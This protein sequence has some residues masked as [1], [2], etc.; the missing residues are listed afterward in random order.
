MD[1]P[2]GA[3]KV[4]EFRAGVGE[5]YDRGWRRIAAP[6]TWWDG[7][8]RVKIAGE[9][10]RAETCNL[11]QQRRDAVSWGA[12]EG[13]HDSSGELPEHLVEII[14]RVRSD[15]SRINESWVHGLSAQGVSEEQY[16]ELIGVVATTIA[17]DT[18]K[19]AALQ[20]LDP[21][22]QPVA[23][24]PSRHRPS[25]AKRNLAWVAT[26]APEDVS[27]EDLNP[28]RGPYAANIHRAMSL[29]PEEV[30]GFFDLVENFYLPSSQMRD[31][32]NEF[33]AITHAQSELIAARLSAINRCIY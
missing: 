31:F 14:H 16:V 6:G 33:R 21:L 25:G 29:V 2:V 4:G 5:A 10:R 17:L 24:E 1:K 19:A 30:S 11:C 3:Q 12:V 15:A 20:P 7:A 28:Y 26:L 8:S 32:G 22:P 23:G 27:E 13:D 9:A 18:F